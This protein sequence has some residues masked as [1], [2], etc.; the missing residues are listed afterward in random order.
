MNAY[1]RNNLIIV[2][3]TVLVALVDLIGMVGSIIVAFTE[4]Y[5]WMWGFWM[6][7]AVLTIIDLI[8]VYR[9]RRKDPPST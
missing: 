3:A 9:I 2:N 4:H 1:D 5:V 7:C 8:V 6:V